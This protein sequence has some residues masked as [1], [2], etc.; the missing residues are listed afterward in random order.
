MGRTPKLHHSLTQPRSFGRFVRVKAKGSVKR[1]P[2]LGRRCPQCNK[3][4]S[5]TTV[6]RKHLMSPRSCLRYVEHDAVGIEEILREASKTAK[7]TSY[8]LPVEAKNGPPN[9]TVTV[10]NNL[11]PA[12]QMDSVS[13]QNGAPV[14]VH[15]LKIDD[16][17]KEFESSFWNTVSPR[18]AS[19]EATKQKTIAYVKNVIRSC[20]YKYLSEVYTKAGFDALQDVFR[21]PITYSTK[22][23]TI[24]AFIEF[25]EFV[26]FNEDLPFNER[27]RIKYISYLKQS[28]TSYAKGCKSDDKDRKIKLGEMMLKGEFPMFS[29]IQ[30]VY[31]RLSSEVEEIMME[32]ELSL[33]SFR[34]FVSYVAFSLVRRCV[35]RPGALVLMTVAEFR[36][37]NRVDDDSFL[38]HVREQKAAT[39]NDGF[40]NIPAITYR[41]LENYLK[42]WRIDAISDDERLILKPNGSP[43]T[44]S[45][46]GQLCKREYQEHYPAK[47]FTFTAFRQHCQTVFS[48]TSNN[49]LEMKWLN[50][51]M[52]HT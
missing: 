1:H 40:V 31:E 50:Q 15:Q 48:S 43:L 17:V 46:L 9:V 4:L 24:A 6:L 36:N 13:D 29:E 19:A 38:V 23:G 7:L 16:L 20:N 34:T 26:E 25:L 30:V 39:Y 12:T 49:E 18:A 21:R 37:P 33:A 11:N 35:I 45:E 52:A 14:D 22:K 42:Q 5:N 41:R 10:N 51:V 2:G 32:D 8:A 3:K 27:K 28:K 44:S 47:S